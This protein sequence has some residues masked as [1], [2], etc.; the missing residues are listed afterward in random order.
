MK[1]FRVILLLIAFA[2]PAFSEESRIIDTARLYYSNKEYYNAITECMRYQSVFPAG[3][4]FGESMILMGQSYF[5]G[6]NSSKAL[7][8]FSDCYT[9]F[10]GSLPGEQALFY[11][12]FVRLKEG[13]YYYS[14]RMFQQYNFIHKEGKFY[15]DSVFNLC[16]T[17]ILAEEYNDAQAALEEYRKQFPG[18]KYFTESEYLTGR[19]SDHVNR[20]VKSP[21]I[22]GLS[23][24]VIPG[25]GY[26]YTEK[27]LLGIFAMLS[28]AGL[29]YLAYDGYRNDNMFQM[30]M[31]SFIELS[32]Y[33]WAV[34]GSILS[35]REYNDNGRFTDEINLRIKVP[36]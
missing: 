31:F 32:F 18:G 23:S 29:I 14:A 5:M 11:S 20:P 6:G 33:N 16:I 3:P 17:R 21:W 8:V 28:N 36:F 27:Y 12:G 9:L 19:I 1:V 4:S 13:S 15:E 25:L 26:I 30:V 10:P 34:T 7:S 35:A 2:V 22:A 24:A